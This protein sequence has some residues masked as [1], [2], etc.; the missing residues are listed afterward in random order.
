M[1]TKSLYDKQYNKV[2]NTLFIKYFIIFIKKNIDILYGK[3]ALEV[4]NNMTITLPYFIYNININ[5]NN[6]FLFIIKIARKYRFIYNK[7]INP[8]NTIYSLKEI[9]IFCLVN[10]EYTIPK[11]VENISNIS[12]LHIIDIYFKYIHNYDYKFLND[13]DNYNNIDNKLNLQLL[14]YNQK[15]DTNTNY[16]YLSYFNKSNYINSGVCI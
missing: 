4:K 7:N 3:T 15:T 12:N 9:P 1:D 11:T 14:K 13:L 8:Y 10:I 5:K 2:L 6:I 16:K